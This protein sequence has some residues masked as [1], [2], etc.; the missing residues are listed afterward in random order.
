MAS[1]VH[2]LCWPSAAPCPSKPLGRPPG[3]WC[4]RWGFVSYGG[5]IAGRCGRSLGGVAD[6]RSLEI[7]N[8][9]LLRLADEAGKNLSAGSGGWKYTGSVIFLDPISQNLLDS[10]RDYDSESY[11]IPRRSSPVTTKQ[12]CCNLEM[13][14]GLTSRYRYFSA[15]GY[16]LISVLPHMTSC[17]SNAPIRL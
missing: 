17:A 5:E 11:S 8:G 3:V 12:L 13:R 14:A 16:L 2:Q 4:C 10:R 6:L 7:G 15:D 1:I 9:G